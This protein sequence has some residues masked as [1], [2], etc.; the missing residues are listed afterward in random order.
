MK[1]FILSN[2]IARNVKL[3]DVTDNMDLKR[4]SDP[5]DKDFV[6]L[7]EYAEVRKLLIGHGAT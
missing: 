4:I 7:K 5:G 6:R 1:D 2:A 3:A